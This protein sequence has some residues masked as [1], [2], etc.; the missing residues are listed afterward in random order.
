VSAR[1]KEKIGSRTPDWEDVVSRVFLSL[2]EVANS[3]KFRGDSS[4]GTLL[5]RITDRRVTDHIREK[6][7]DGRFVEEREVAIYDATQSELEY[8]Q[9]LGAVV[10]AMERLTPRQREVFAMFGLG[11][12]TAGETARNLGIS[13]G[14]VWKTYDRAR[15]KL[16]GQLKPWMAKEMEP[17]TLVN[18]TERFWFAFLRL[19]QKRGRLDE[20]TEH[21]ARIAKQEIVRRLMER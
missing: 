14:T 17:L 1:V 16:A 8:S 3:G 12:M 11:E 7:K 19:G 6:Y 21:F 9:F 18:W 10:S 13:K 20:T 4:V 5:F 2:V 15:E